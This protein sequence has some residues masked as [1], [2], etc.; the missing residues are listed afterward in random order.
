MGDTAGTAQSTGADGAPERTS[1][2][3]AETEV[4]EG[5]HWALLIDPNYEPEQPGDP[6]PEEAIVGAWY[7]DEGGVPQRFT[8]NHAYRPSSPDVPTDPLDAQL[9]LAA[10]GEASAEDFV[11]TLPGATFCIALDEDDSAIVTRAPDGCPSVLVVTALA[12]AH[13]LH[14]PSWQEITAERLAALLPAEGVDLL[15]NPGA[16]A[17]VRLGADE[18]R[19]ALAQERS[20]AAEDPGGSG[21]TGAGDRRNEQVAGGRAP[22][23]S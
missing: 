15:F 2:G 7:V 13:R 17:S 19:H 22:S 6:V 11:A 18:F 8:P 4:L 10:R 14:V 16:E 12:H 3:A 23:G 9:R 5:D 20:P 21:I 1:D